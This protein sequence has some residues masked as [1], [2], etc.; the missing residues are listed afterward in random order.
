MADQTPDAVSTPLSESLQALHE[1]FVSYM[2]A[3][4][5]ERQALIIC[6]ELM[7]GQQQ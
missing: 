1:L 7:R 3:G 6:V 5:T 2:E 4:F